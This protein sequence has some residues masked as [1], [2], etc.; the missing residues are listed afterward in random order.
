LTL[1]LAALPAYAVQR[2]V[3]VEDFTNAG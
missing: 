2:M 3:V 1:L